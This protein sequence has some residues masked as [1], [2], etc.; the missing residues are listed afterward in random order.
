V[1]DVISVHWKRY[2]DETGRSEDAVVD[3][4]LSITNCYVVVMN[5]TKGNRLPQELRM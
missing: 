3:R 2:E 5:K 4:R 1:V